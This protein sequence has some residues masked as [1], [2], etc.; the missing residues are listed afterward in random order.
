MEQLFEMLK[1]M[2]ADQAKA[3]AKRKTDKDFL[4]R[5][6]PDRK[7]DKISSQD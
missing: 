1:E 3:E 7:K 5:L 6:D 4:A 2:K